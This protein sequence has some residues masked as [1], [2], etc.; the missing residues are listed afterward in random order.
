MTPRRKVKHTR[1]WVLRLVVD[2]LVGDRDCL[3]VSG[4]QVRRP[5]VQRPGVVR[6]EQVGAL[7]GETRSSASTS[8]SSTAGSRPPG[9][10]SSPMRLHE[11]WVAEGELDSVVP[12]ELP[13]CAQG[14]CAGASGRRRARCCTPSRRTTDNIDL[15]GLED[16]PM[17]TI[18][19]TGSS[20]SS[21]PA[22][23]PRWSG[24]CPAWPAA[25]GRT[26][27]APCSA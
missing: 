6:T 13:G 4:F 19:S 16:A 7:Q 24:W 11:L 14:W 17:L 26:P 25:P 23:E 12:E 20:N 22:C 18:R 27:T 3:V 21:S 1:S 15:E 10:I 5:H 2:R 8:M 9:K